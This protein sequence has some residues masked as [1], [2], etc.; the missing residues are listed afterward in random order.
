MFP[1]SL[2]KFALP[3]PRP[4]PSAQIE[5]KRTPSITRKKTLLISPVTTSETWLLSCTKKVKP[6][7]SQKKTLLR[8]EP[9]KVNVN[10]TS[11]GGASV[12]RT[13]GNRRLEAEKSR[14]QEAPTSIT[15]PT[16]INDNL[17]V[18]PP[19]RSGH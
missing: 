5:L 4:C 10:P 8:K 18:L 15:V 13:Y 6:S 19:D 3:R 12:K 7:K 11:E 9:V 16:K 2:L 17:Y 14:P 1:V